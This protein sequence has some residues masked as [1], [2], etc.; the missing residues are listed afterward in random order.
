M[1]RL[2]PRT[3]KGARLTFTPSLF[4]FP[5]NHFHPLL[6][7]LMSIRVASSACF[8][9]RALSREPSS[10]PSISPAPSSL[11]GEDEPER[12][13]AQADLLPSFLLFL[14]SSSS[15][16]FF[17]SS[18]LPLSFDPSI[19]TPIYQDLLSDILLLCISS[20]LEPTQADPQLDLYTSSLPSRRPLQPNSNRRPCRSSRGSSRNQNSYQLRTQGSPVLP[21]AER[22][23][24]ALLQGAIPPLHHARRLRRRVVHSIL[25]PFRRSCT[26][27]PPSSLAHPRPSQLCL[28]CGGRAVSVRACRGAELTFGSFHPFFFLFSRRLSVIN[29]VSRSRPTWWHGRTEGL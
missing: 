1:F 2:S 19:F 25:P 18:A 23:G 5:S 7:S 9:R 6:L 14:P 17:S 13:R 11:C 16:L 21:S 15:L 12:S 3:S 22:D 29:R 24:E 20:L 28:V 8:A 26:S 10:F 27:L 4:F